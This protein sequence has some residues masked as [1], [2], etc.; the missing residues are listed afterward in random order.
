MITLDAFLVFLLAASLPVAYLW[1]VSRW[2]EREYR[3]THPAADSPTSAAPV[4]K[5][6]MAKAA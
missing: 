1:I 4:S 3:A 5:P 6:L 2:V